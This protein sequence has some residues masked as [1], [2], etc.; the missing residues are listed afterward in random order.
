MTQF[1]LNSYQDHRSSNLT[2]FLLVP[3]TLGWN[4]NTCTAKK[5]KVSHLT[6]LELLSP[7]LIKLCPVWPVYMVRKHQDGYPYL[8]LPQF[9]FFGITD[10]SMNSQQ[11]RADDYKA[12]FLKNH[13]YFQ[14]PPKNGNKVGTVFKTEM[15]EWVLKICHSFF[16]DNLQRFFFFGKI[17]GQKTN[18]TKATKGRGLLEVFLAISFSF[19][20]PQK[21]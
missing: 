12:Y 18:A 20:T 21:I 14:H 4:Y 19:N 13:F 15:L 9:V 8:Y 5:F 10:W 7:C 6:K 17:T 1:S 16:L 11:Q 2:F 3:P